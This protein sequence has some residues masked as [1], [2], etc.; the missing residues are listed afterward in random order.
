MN[1]NRGHVRGMAVGCALIQRFVVTHI[2]GKRRFPTLR[3][4]TIYARLKGVIFSIFVA[5]YVADRTESERL[6]A[7]L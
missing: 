7:S 3:E 1:P 4:L 5:S 6:K 2:I